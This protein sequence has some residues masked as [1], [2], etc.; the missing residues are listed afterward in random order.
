[1]VW[2]QAR[3]LSG[4]LHFFVLYYS[5]RAQLNLGYISGFK[6]IVYLVACWQISAVA[7]LCA[8]LSSHARLE[9]FV[10]QTKL[11]QLQSPAAICNPFVP[12]KQVVAA[13]RLFVP[14]KQVVVCPFTH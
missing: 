3:N 9:A 4:E 6:G 13:K 2:H 12:A 8:F 5:T 1:M 10:I 14:A 11:M 7:C